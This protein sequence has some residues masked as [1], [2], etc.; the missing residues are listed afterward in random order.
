MCDRDHFDDD[1][2]KYLAKGAVTRR[3]FGAMVG[4]GMV[5]LLPRVANAVDVT[6]TDVDVRTPDGV[7]D[8]R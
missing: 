4:A 8:W 7:A 3:Q 1:L 5:M 2:Q 6:E